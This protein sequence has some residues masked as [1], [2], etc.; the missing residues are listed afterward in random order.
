MD[1]KELKQ[2]A[3]ACREAGIRSFKNS[4]VE[5]TLSEDAPVSNYKKRKANKVEEDIKSVLLSNDP[6]EED[7]LFWSVTEA[8][9][10]TNQ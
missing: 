2:L 6:S 1:I 4:E 3:K 10:E 7:M 5:F 8:Q 9:Q